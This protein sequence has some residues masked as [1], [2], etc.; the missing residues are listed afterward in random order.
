MKKFFLVVAIAFTAISTN[1]QDLKF[2]AK[3]GLNINSINL[4][5]EG[6]DGE[7]SGAKF[8]LGFHFGVVADYA[9]SEKLSLRPGLGFARKGAKRKESG[10]ETITDLNYIQ[11]DFNVAY[12]FGSFEATAGPYAAF[13]TGGKEK[14]G[15]EEYSIKPSFSQVSAEDLGGDIGVNGLDLGLNIGAGYHIADNMLI[16]YQLSFG[17]SNLQ[18]KRDD[19][20]S[21]VRKDF[22]T[23]NTT[24]N[25]S[26]TYFFN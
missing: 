24:S 9:L 14:V 11:T 21:D 19:L 15:D 23:T 7:D 12:K 8:D 4:V 1:A 6:F 16:S 10:V 20:S 13:L 18:G 5:G 3:G 17:L 26:F 22:K 2:G 25:F